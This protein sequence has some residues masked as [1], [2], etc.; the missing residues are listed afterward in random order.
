MTVQKPIDA[1]ILSLLAGI[2]ILIGAAFHI[3]VGETL[4][5]FLIPRFFIIGRSLFLFGLTGLIC[6]ILVL[7]GAFIIISKPANT[8]VGGIIVIAFS[9][10][11]IFGAIGGFIIGMIL[12]IIGG[13]LAIYWKPGIIY[14]VD[15][16]IE[17]ERRR[18]CPYCGRSIIFDAKA[19]P[20]CGKRI[21]T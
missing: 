14:E 1:F 6:G 20:Y 21:E 18:F 4:G 15:T 2:F 17:E 7:I 9:I 8:K 10:L 12:G 16:E 19:C 11:S 5:W 3:I 13:V